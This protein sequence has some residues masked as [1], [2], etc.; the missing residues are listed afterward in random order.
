MSVIISVLDQAIILIRKQF[1][2]PQIKE[3]PYGNFQGIDNC[4]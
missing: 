2:F 3:I 1:N 4:S